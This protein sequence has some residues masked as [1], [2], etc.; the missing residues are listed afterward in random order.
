[1]KILKA[2]IATSISS[3]VE[4]LLVL[5]KTFSSDPSANVPL[6]EMLTP[7]AKALIRMKMK[8][9]VAN[10]LEVLMTVYRGDCPRHY[11]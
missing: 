8:T 7:K 1:M 6:S 4:Y 10:H 9:E 5:A 2:E 11:T 3:F